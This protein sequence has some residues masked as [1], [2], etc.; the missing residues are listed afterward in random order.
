MVNDRGEMFSSQSAM[1][2][3]AA[4]QSHCV[5]LLIRTGFLLVCFVLLLCCGEKRETPT[6]S[7]PAKIA[8]VVP[9]TGPLMEEGQMLQFG[10][11]MAS[12]E[13]ASKADDLNLEVVVYDSPCDPAGSVVTAKRLT[14]DS[15]VS[16]VIGYLCAETLGAV[17]PIYQDAGLA[18]INPT[19]SADYVRR[20]ETRNLFSLLY[21]DGD[22][23]AFLA[24]YAKEGLGLD[25]V[26]ILRDAS[27]YGSVLSS[28]FDAEAT[29][30]D[31]KVVANV[32]INS[33]RAAAA[34]AVKSL[35][36]TSP[37]GV[38]LAASP[39]A[40]S[41]FLLER[42]RQ[43]LAGVVLGPDQLADLDFYEMAGQAAEGLLVCQPILFETENREKSRFVSRFEQLYKR[44]PDWIAAA[45]YDAMRL[46]LK[47]LNNS[48]PGRRAFLQSVRTISG[49]DTAFEGLSGPVF[50]KEDGT[51]RRP[52]FV[53]AV[54]GGTLRAAKPPTVEFPVALSTEK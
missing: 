42:Q 4:S 25:R 35:K 33:E 5:R 51:S 31:L 19:V 40:A 50:F 36:R 13:A 26:A 11:L 52:L 41:L 22:Q 28:A 24:T 8:V 15:A 2:L 44:Q 29:R 6:W 46:T 39:R 54:Q 49:P 34:Q 10:A 7:G 32:A 1:N 14:T 9:H 45:G 37:E 16:A 27:A 53:G 18:L 30:L 17:L 3:V 47:V 43:H 20:R 38:F 48:G 12:R 21:A 23:A